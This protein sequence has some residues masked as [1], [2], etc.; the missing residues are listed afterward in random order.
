MCKK[1]QIFKFEYE[2]HANLH[3]TNEKDLFLHGFIL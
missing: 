3:N 2:V 1:P